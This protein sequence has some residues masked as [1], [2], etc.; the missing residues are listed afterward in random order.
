MEMEMEMGMGMGMGIEIE[1]RSVSRLEFGKQSP[2]IAAL[3]GMQLDILSFWCL[4]L[5]SERGARSLD[6]PAR[7]GMMVVEFVVMVVASATL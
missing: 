5:N 1:R 4:Y 2:C 7:S 6:P 3:W